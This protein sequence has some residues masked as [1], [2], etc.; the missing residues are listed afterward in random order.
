MIYRRFRSK[1]S[2]VFLTVALYVTI[3]VIWLIPLQ[4]ALEGD[5]LV[6]AL[7]STGAVWLIRWL[8][9]GLAGEL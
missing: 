3:G 7:M 2:A 8:L 1:P 9:N 6:A 5:W 4:F